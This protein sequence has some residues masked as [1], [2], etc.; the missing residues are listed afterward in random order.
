MAAPEVCT[1]SSDD[2]PRL[3]LAHAAGPGRGDAARVAPP[4][5]F[6]GARVHRRLHDEDAVLRELPAPEAFDRLLVGGEGNVV[7][8]PAAMADVA[9]SDA[10]QRAGSWAQ[11]LREVARL[12]HHFAQRR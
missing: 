2:H 11:L 3:A 4:D 12:F 9:G 8:Q 7:T 10:G 5:A 1:L 6:A